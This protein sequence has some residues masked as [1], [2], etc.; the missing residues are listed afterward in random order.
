MPLKPLDFERTKNVV[1][2]L[3]MN[4][5]TAFGKQRSLVGRQG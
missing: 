5:R 3:A 1:A 2:P 4:R